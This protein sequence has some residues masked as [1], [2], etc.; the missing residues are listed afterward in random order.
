M[1]VNSFCFTKSKS[2]D[3]AEI[4]L[5]L[6]SLLSSS[7]GSRLMYLRYTNN[8]FFLHFLHNTYSIFKCTY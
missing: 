4:E 7:S 8:V 2:A 5:G 1:K 3:S 6:Q